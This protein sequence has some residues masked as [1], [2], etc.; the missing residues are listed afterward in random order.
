V[1]PLA[2]IVDQDV[3]PPVDIQAAFHQVPQ[4][5]RV[6]DVGGNGHGSGQLGGQPSSRSAR[7]AASTTRAPRPA[8]RRAV[9]A[10][11]PDEAPVTIATEPSILIK[12]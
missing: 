5:G 7:R 9:A 4:L 12:S 11:M 8:S 10:P 6:G 2:G 3:D 1:K